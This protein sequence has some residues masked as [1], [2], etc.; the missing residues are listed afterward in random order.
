MLSEVRNDPAISRA[1]QGIISGLLYAPQFVII[2][3]SCL[4]IYDISP[5][6]NDKVNCFEK[7]SVSPSFLYDLSGRDS[8]KALGQRPIAPIS[9]AIHG[10]NYGKTPV[11]YRSC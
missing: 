8:N 1:P 9:G 10:L 6:V 2:R 11:G 5:P 4:R 7:M 3:A